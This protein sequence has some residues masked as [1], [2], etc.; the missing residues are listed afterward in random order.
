MVNDLY[1][2][3]L[4]LPCCHLQNDDHK[5]RYI[6]LQSDQIASQ[7]CGITY[8]G[9]GRIFRQTILAFEEIG[10]VLGLFFWG[11]KAVSFS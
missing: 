1:C 10:F 5:S 4:A 8:N 6:L 7:I 3:A 11:L 9:C 2:T